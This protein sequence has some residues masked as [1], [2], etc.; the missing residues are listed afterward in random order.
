VDDG[1]AAIAQKD[2]ELAAAAASAALLATE[3]AANK[4]L[5]DAVQAELEREQQEHAAR[6]AE[7]E[8]AADTAR[9]AA[10][11][12]RAELEAERRAWEDAAAATAAEIG[13]LRQRAGSVERELA[14]AVAAGRQKDS[15]LA[16]CDEAAKRLSDEAEAARAFDTREDTTT[17]GFGLGC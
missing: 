5:A 10:E 4:A 1:L 17:S 15:E 14:D 13:S 11:A 16:A 3:S 2:G 8:K 12:L 7:A 9:Q 6:L